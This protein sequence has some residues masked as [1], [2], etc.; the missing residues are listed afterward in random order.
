MQ[1]KKFSLQDF[2][3]GRQL[4]REEMKKVG[5]GTYYYN[6]KCQC[7]GVV[8]TWLGTYPGQ[9]EANNSIPDACGSNGGTCTEGLYPKP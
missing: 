7:N 9:T 6:Y 2:T 1:T 8:G 5:G 4:S 3:G